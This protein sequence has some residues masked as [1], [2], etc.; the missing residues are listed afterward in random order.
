MRV[1]EVPVKTLEDELA[2]LTKLAEAYEGADFQNQFLHGSITTLRW[3]LYR[4]LSP[5]E[6]FEQT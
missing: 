6:T 2:R 4:V 5:S 3:M 1:I